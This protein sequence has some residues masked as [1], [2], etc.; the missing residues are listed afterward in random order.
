MQERIAIWHYHTGKSIHA[1]VG[2]ICDYSFLEGIVRDFQPEAVV[3]FGEQRSA[4]YSMIDRRH[5]VFTQHNNVIGTLNL[6]YAIAFVQQHG[7]A[8]PQPAHDFEAEVVQRASLKGRR[9]AAVT[10]LADDHGGYVP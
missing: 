9:Q 10:L 7:F 3:H 1:F 2:D 8:R 6:L 4:P 5:A